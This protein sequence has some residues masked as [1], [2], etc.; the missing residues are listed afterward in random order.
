ML[1]RHPLGFE[2]GGPVGGFTCGVSLGF[3]LL[4]TVEALGRTG[5]VGED[6]ADFFGG[7]GRW[8]LFGM[9]RRHD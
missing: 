7:I 4:E 3:H 1:G 2:N 9:G 5:G 8:K 6:L